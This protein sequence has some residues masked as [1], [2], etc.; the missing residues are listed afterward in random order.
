M[1]FEKG[2][3]GNPGGRPKSDKTLQELAK[4]HAPEAISTL[5]AVMV[6]VKSPPAARVS[7]AT[8]ILDRGYG[9]PAQAI[10]HSGAVGAYD[11]AKLAELSDEELAAFELLL[12]RIATGNADPGDDPSS[13]G[14]EGD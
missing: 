11:P 7:A 6:D 14:E 1:P 9:K 4:A 5:A 2:K 8:A 13:E 10:K 12:T 3:S